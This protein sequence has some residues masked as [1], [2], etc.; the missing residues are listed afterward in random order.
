MAEIPP[1]FCFV[2][3]VFPHNTHSN[4]HFHQPKPTE[5]S[6]CTLDQTITEKKTGRGN[7]KGQYLLFQ[8]YSDTDLMFLY[9]SQAQLGTETV[10]STPQKWRYMPAVRELYTAVIGS[11]STHTWSGMCLRAV[12]LTRVSLHHTHLMDCM[13]KA[14]PA[15]A[16]ELAYTQQIPQTFRSE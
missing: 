11:S 1:Q 9:F 4:L 6:S 13:C 10:Y 14:N 15:E 12:C 7:R 16:P 2:R 8:P 3:V 5:C